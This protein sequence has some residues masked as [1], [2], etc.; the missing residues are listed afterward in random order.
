[1]NDNIPGGLLN[2]YELREAGSSGFLRIEELNTKLR[3]LKRKFRSIYHDIFLLQEL[4]KETRLFDTD[5]K[6]RID[7]RKDVLEA[8][9]P[10][11]RFQGNELDWELRRAIET[12]FAYLGIKPHY[13]R[14][15]GWHSF[16]RWSSEAMHDEALK[17]QNSTFAERMSLRDTL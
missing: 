11:I 3:E 7:T 14:D 10:N 5:I 4:R 15:Y 2:Y 8:L 9:L 17:A 16:S 1:M 6:Y 12:E 13:T